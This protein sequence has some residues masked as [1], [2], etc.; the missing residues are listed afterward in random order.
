M[1]RS[2]PKGQGT[3]A[4]WAVGHE[5]IA[6]DTCLH[7]FGG[8]GPA[9]VERSV[10]WPLRGCCTGPWPLIQP[11]QTAHVA[12]HWFP[13]IPPPATQN[14]LDTIGTAPEKNEKIR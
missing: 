2:L 10:S 5:T 7:L 14:W 9:D 3:S 8:S 6:V 11:P 1:G 4:S 13:G 12:G